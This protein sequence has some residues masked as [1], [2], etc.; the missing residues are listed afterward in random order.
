[1]N[2]IERKGSAEAQDYFQQRQKKQKGTEWQGYHAASERLVALLK[3]CCFYSEWKREG[4]TQNVSKNGLICLMHF[5]KCISLSGAF[6]ECLWTNWLPHQPVTDV[7][8]LPVN[9]TQIYKM[10]GFGQ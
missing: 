3:I 5:R 1:M 7:P 2:Y 9:I 4:E 6:W 10:E 8:E